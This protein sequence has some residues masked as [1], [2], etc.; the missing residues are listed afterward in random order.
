M[1]QLLPFC[2]YYTLHRQE[3]FSNATVVFALTLL[4]PPKQAD[5]EQVSPDVD[6]KHS[7]EEEVDVEALNSHPAKSGQ[8]RPV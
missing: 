2:S 7:D 8:Q 5:F 4:T 1:L 3:L 6:V